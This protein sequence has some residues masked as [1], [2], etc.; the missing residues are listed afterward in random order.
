V[1]LAGLAGRGA[2]YGTGL[3]ESVLGLQCVPARLAQVI[4]LR[5][6]RQE[7]DRYRSALARRG[8]AEDF[9]ALLAADRRWRELTERAEKLRAQQKRASRGTPP[10]PE[11]I[12]ELRQL[13]KELDG[14]EADQAE[15]ERERQ[16][17]L[18]RIPN[19]PDPTAADGLTEE[20]SVVLR[21]WGEP[22]QFTFPVRDATDLGSGTWP[23][24][25]WPCTGSSSTA[26][27]AR[28]S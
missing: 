10:S 18:D 25:R 3:A 1:R 13:R 8:A 14:A 12:A 22:P 28:D 4:D 24:P 5:A 11:E 27:P 15:A 6:A 26:W 17:L 16:T 2:E 9:D 23:W 21:T 19:L 7:A 20:D